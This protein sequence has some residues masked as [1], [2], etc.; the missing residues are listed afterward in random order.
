M[1]YSRLPRSKLS[2]SRIAPLPM[3]ESLCWY[4]VGDWKSPNMN[5]LAAV[6]KQA[7]GIDCCKWL[8][9]QA[10]SSVADGLLIRPGL[11]LVKV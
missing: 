3:P 8:L 7:L 11:L 6:E 10:V 9:I 1:K 4:A 2:L 5:M